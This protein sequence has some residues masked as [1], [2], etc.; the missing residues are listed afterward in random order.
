M[1]KAGSATSVPNSYQTRTPK[2]A[3]RSR[4]KSALHR[5]LAIPNRPNRNSMEAI[6]K[7]RNAKVWR[8]DTLALR[9]FSLGLGPNGAGKSSFLKLLTGE[10]QPEADPATRCRLFGEDWWLCRGSVLLTDKMGGCGRRLLLR[11]GK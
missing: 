2:F 8:S 7:I 1:G 11:F 10:V 3:I 9:D 6:L 5:E 4:R